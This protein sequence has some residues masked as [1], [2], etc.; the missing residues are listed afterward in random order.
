MKTLFICL[1]V[2]LCVLFGLIAYS[3]VSAPTT[4]IEKAQADAEQEAWIR[5]WKKDHAN[6]PQ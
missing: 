2:A 5:Q 4:E 1:I 3:A 6:D